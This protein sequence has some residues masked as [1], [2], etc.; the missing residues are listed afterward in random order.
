MEK[1]IITKSNQDQAIAAWVD[2][3]NQI[4]LDNLIEALKKQDINLKNALE[5]INQ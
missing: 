1:D 2:Y 3:L 4:R 5:I